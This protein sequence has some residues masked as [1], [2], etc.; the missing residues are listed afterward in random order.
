MYVCGQAA[1]QPA[2]SIMFF[3]QKK[4]FEFRLL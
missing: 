4:E 1:I 3:K 2:L